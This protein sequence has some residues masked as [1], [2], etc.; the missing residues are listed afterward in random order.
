MNHGSRTFSI[1]APSGTGKSS[2]SYTGSAFLCPLMTSKSTHALFAAGCVI[3][4]AAAAA[5]A[6]AVA[7][8]VAGVAAGTSPSP[9]SSELVSLL[10]AHRSELRLL[11]S[12]FFAA[13]RS[14]RIAW[15][16]S[17]HPRIDMRGNRVADGERVYSAKAAAEDL[18]RVYAKNLA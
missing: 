1:G 8:A 11:A 12:D 16:S 17:Q 6:A 7:G 3:A 15:A 5:A 18:D 13:A 9:S 4:A 10:S 2:S 14:A